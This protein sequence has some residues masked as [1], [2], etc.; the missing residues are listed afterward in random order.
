MTIKVKMDE[1]NIMIDTCDH[2]NNVAEQSHAC[3]SQDCSSTPSTSTSS[4]FPSPAAINQQPFLHVHSSLGNHSSF[5]PEMEMMKERFAKLLL[6]KDM[7]GSGKGVSTALAISNAITNLCATLFGQ[8][9]RLE[10][11]PPEKK[12]MWRREMEW[13]LC[14][15]DHIVELIPTWQTFPNG[16]KLEVYTPRIAPYARN[17]MWFV[18]NGL[19][20][21]PTSI[22]YW[23]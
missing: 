13:L 17:L 10:P 1:N 15:G 14:V 6:G 2:Q 20:F 21:L 18:S 11:V 9:W 22:Y 19:S 12:A 5:M 16:S 8:L 3:N 7:S 4:P 23:L